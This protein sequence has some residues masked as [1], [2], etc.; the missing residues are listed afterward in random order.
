MRRLDGGNGIPLGIIDG[1]SY[2]EQR[3]QLEPGDSLVLFSD[4]VLESKNRQGAGFG[5]ARLE[6]LIR[7]PWELPSELISRLVDALREHRGREGQFDD[8]TIMVLSRC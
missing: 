3:L 6:E 7:G 1:F 2:E 4:G 5:F 8:I